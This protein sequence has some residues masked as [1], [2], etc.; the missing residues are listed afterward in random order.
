MGINKIILFLKKEKRKNETK[1]HYYEGFIFNFV[2][3]YFIYVLMYYRHS[4]Q[5]SNNNNDDLIAMD[6]GLLM[7][8]NGNRALPSFHLQIAKG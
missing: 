2:V 6:R 4:D 1:S 7:E 5:T 8:E 3:P